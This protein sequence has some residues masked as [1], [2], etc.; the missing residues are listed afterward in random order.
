MRKLT[1]SFAVLALA[2]SAMASDTATGEFKQLIDQYWKA[3]STLDPDKP[4]VMYV[5]NADAVFYDITPLKYNGWNEY[6]EGVKKLFATAA[7]ASFA[8]NDDLKVTRK[9]NIAW[10]TSTFHGT[11]NRKD[12]KTMQLQGRH[13]AIWEKRG[14]KWLIVHEH[15][16]APLPE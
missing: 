13:T 12:G 6:K 10:T 7:S 11:I 2:V 14:G 15:V 9:G 3:W 1:A 5:Q 4:A 8:A 16:S